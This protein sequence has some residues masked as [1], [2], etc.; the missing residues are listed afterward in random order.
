M[1]LTPAVP[2]KQ[3]ESHCSQFL[4]DVLDGLSATPKHLQSKYFYDEQ[5]DKLFQEIMNCPE[6]YLTGLEMEIFTQQTDLLAHTI[7]KG[8]EPFDLIELGAGDATKSIH[9][10]RKLVEQGA[11]FEY[12]PI[13]IS[14]HVISEL[15]VTL[16]VSVPGLKLT[17][18]EGE[19]FEMLAKASAISDRRKVVMFLGSNIGNMPVEDAQEFCNSLRQHLSTGDMLLMGVDLKKNPNIIRAA[20]D[21][22]GGITKAFNLNL[23]TRINRELGA[24]FDLSQFDH[25]CSYDP[26]TGACKSYL[27]SLSEQVVKING[28]SIRFEKDEYIW[29]EISQKYTIDQVDEMAEKAGFAP[30]DHIFDSKHWF[31]DAMLVAI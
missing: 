25:F 27:I 3:P 1:I 20:Y 17:G 14:G 29:M 9:L 26:E 12:M 4:H 8:G 24:D 30:A 16:P 13:D 21:D 2:E 11:Q 22:K 31:V 7:R 28:K 5:G 6:Y 19:Y 15:E 10:L 23:L 18:L